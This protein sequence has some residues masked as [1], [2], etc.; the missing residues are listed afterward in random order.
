MLWEVV[1]QS[2]ISGALTFPLSDNQ[3]SSLHSVGKPPLVLNVRTVVKGER[4]S[5]RLCP[6]WVAPQWHLLHRSRRSPWVLHSKSKLF[7]CEFAVPI[8]NALSTWMKFDLLHLIYIVF[9]LFF[10]LKQSLHKHTEACW[11]YFAFP[12]KKEFWRY[13]VGILDESDIWNVHD[14]MAIWPLL[15]ESSEVAANYI[16]MTKDAC[17]FCPKACD[18][19]WMKWSISRW[20]IS[21]S[22]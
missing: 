16:L 7:C 10:V 11:N 17:K 3:C 1:M 14:G 21:I 5:W 19:F 13:R 6:F 15:L 2:P 4:L 12:S 8:W 9:F 22:Y 20:H 18:L